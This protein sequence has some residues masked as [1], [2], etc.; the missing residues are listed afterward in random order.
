MRIQLKTSNK[1]PL[2]IACDRLV[3]S[4]GE[5]QVRLH[6]LPSAA[7]GA[8]ITQLIHDSNQ[9]M[10]LLLVTKTADSMQPGTNGVCVKAGG[11]K[12][13]WPVYNFDLYMN[14]KGAD[15]RV[16]MKE[17]EGSTFELKADL[18][19]LAMG[20]VG[21]RKAGMIEQSGVTLDPRG[22]VAANVRLKMSAT[23]SD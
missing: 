8:N 9:F 5:V 21:P 12:V 18:V 2:E 20:F 7:D 6:D 22:N 11:A 16:A 15:G 1:K 10:E 19:L 4:G 17:V 3:F 23:R 13:Y 14:V